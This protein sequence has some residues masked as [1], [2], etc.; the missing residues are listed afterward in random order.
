MEYSRSNVGQ[1]SLDEFVNVVAGIYSLHDSHRSIWDVWCHTLH[2]AAGIAQQARREAPPKL[3]KEIAHFSLWLFTTVLKLTGEFGVVK[4]ASETAQTSLIRIRS[5][6]SDLLWQKYP[7]LCPS[8]A[9]EKIA[10]GNA[11]DRFGQ[12]FS[13]E[14][15]THKSKIESD[16]MRR[17]RLDEV[18]EYSGRII[19]EKPDRIDEWQKMFGNLF[20]KNLSALSLT[21]IAFHLLEELGETS[22]AMIR[23]YSYTEDDFQVGGPNRRQINLESQLADVFSWLFAFVEKL[24]FSPEDLEKGRQQEYSAKRDRGLIFL[25]RIIWDSYGSDVLHAFHCAKCKKARCSCPII[26]VPDTRS[27]EELRMKYQ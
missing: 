22:D 24:D 18:R 16:E 17:I 25:S 1:M 5:K 2:H 10:D 12:L 21:D 3:Y 13:C 26:L 6:C 14:C 27:I 23:M 15:Q 11:L 9:M 7:K 20:A 8:C 19:R 4:D